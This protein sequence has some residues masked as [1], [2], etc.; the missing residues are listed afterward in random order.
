M[1]ACVL[2]S[3][4][5]GNITYVETSSHKYLLDIGRNKKYVLEDQTSLF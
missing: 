4:S 1:K 2:S 5:K 3:G